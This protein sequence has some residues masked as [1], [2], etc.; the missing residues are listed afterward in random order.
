MVQRPTVVGRKAHYI[1]ANKLAA[2]Y[3]VC[4]AHKSTNTVQLDGLPENVVP[5]SKQT[6]SIKCDMPNDDAMCVSGEQVSVLPNFAMTDFASQGRTHPFNVVIIVGA[7]DWCTLACQEVLVARYHFA[8]KDFI[9]KDTRWFDRF[10]Y[11]EFRELEIL[12]DITRLH[13]LGELPPSVS[14]V[15]RTGLIRSYQLLKGYRA[16]PKDCPSFNWMSRHDPMNLV[17]KSEDASWQLVGKRS[18]K[19]CAIFG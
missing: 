9:K 15:T 14:A 3:L 11:T 1:T 18:N 16:C 12:D 7:I 17:D 4:E 5:L 6:I 8:G 2:G 13:Y 10:P 19:P